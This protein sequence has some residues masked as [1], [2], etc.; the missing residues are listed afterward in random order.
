MSKGKLM[1][2]DIHII[3]AIEVFISHGINPGSCVELL[4]RGEYDEAYKHAHP[5]IKPYW[6][7]HIAYVE[8]M[9]EACRGENFDDWIGIAG[10]KTKI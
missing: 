4:L 3:E 6:E 8:S 7:D 9:P 5:L 1:N 2:V 10:W